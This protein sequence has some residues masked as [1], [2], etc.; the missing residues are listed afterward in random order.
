[1]REDVRAKAKIAWERLRGG[2]LTP[3]RAG[4]SV[5]VGLAI[6]VTPL[7][8]LHL[9]LV[10]AACLPLRLD[11]PVA[12]LAANISM[13]LIAP[14]LSAAEIEI[15]AF[16]LTGH[17]LPAH[18]ADVR[19][20][21]AGL[22]AKELFAGTLVFSPSI[23]LVGGALTF[24]GVRGA[25]K[26]SGF[27]PDEL[28]A[29]IERVARRY[30]ARRDGPTY[31]Y[32]RSKLA[33]DPVT[34]QVAKE[35]AAASLGQV[36]DAGCGRG[37]LAVLLLEL[38]VASQVVGFDWDAKKIIA[39][40]GASAGLPA[41]FHQGDLKA[42]MATPADTVLLIDVLH[43]LED[44]E[45]DRVLREA[46]RVARQTVIVRELD[47]DRGWR[48]VVTRLAEA[49][50]TGIG[51][52]RGA[53]VNA[54]PI[55]KLKDV[56][57]GEGFRVEVTPCWGGTPFSNVLLTARRLPVTAGERPPLGPP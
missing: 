42:P 43:Y 49:L 26:P 10:L 36:L 29:A 57:E 39:A 27:V 53:R 50:T 12:Y 35:G 38:G 9:L 47:P 44:G 17:G 25:R 16:V 48:S 3:W 5:A 55:A 11:A 41:T 20:Q 6:G 32:V 31:V 52:N 24:L 4:A 2:E 54:R 18:F 46:A 19:A 13:P 56:L 22:F 8:G 23:A 15:G 14:F 1:M 40:A 30:A 34:R 51:Y 45:Q 21:A 28:T 7:W 33:T 37:Q